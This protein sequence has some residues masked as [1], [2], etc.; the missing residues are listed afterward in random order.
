MIYMGSWFFEDLSRLSLLRRVVL[1]ACCLW[2]FGGKV[3][4]MALAMGITT[5]VSSDSHASRSQKH[6]YQQLRPSLL[7]F[8][9]PLLPFNTHPLL[10]AVDFTDFRHHS[11][12]LFLDSAETSR[13]GVMDRGYGSHAPCHSYL[14]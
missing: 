14:S 7:Q 8:P 6:Y 12:A 3:E 13:V 4:Q 1:S 2:I 9:H 10:M 11:L 5:A